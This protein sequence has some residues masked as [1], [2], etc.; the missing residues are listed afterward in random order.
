MHIK[1]HKHRHALLAP[2]SLGMLTLIFVLGI[3]PTFSAS[4]Q[5]AETDVFL[6]EA[7]V[8]RLAEGAV[9]AQ[10][11][12][13]PELKNGSLLVQTRGLVHLRIGPSLLTGID[14]AFYVTRSDN[15]LSIV[16]LTSPVLFEQGSRQM[17]I[18]P[19]QQWRHSY[20]PLPTLAAGSSLWMSTRKTESVSRTFIQ[21]QLANIP[22]IPADDQGQPI[23][24]NPFAV[25]PVAHQ[26]QHWEPN[27]SVQLSESQNTPIVRGPL[28]RQFVNADVRHWVLLSAHPQYSRYVWSAI[29]EELNASQQ[30]LALLALPLSDTAQQSRTLPVLREWAD[31]LN[32]SLLSADDS[33]DTS[34]SIL[35]V[36]T[37]HLIAQQKD[38]YPARARAVADVLLEHIEEHTSSISPELNRHMR[39]LQEFAKTEVVALPV[40]PTEEEEVVEKEEVTE[41]VIALPEAEVLARAERI[42]QDARALFTVDTVIRNTDKPNVAAVE[43]II[44]SSPSKDRMFSFE[45]DVHAGSIFNVEEDGQLYSYPLWVEDF[46]SWAQS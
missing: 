42:L 37:P 8:G 3:N 14:G 11:A 9:I 16:S 41:E 33:I 44:F 26:Q 17:L 34:L 12:E 31:V 6:G 5:L 45:I 24:A 38:G 29:P 46:V 13:I 10:D 35:S 18:A 25:L 36:L 1:N 28:I 27:P 30:L 23:V 21:E 40:A 19:G 22:S 32:T 39:T 20:E 15:R 2:L 7:A 43:G 4:L